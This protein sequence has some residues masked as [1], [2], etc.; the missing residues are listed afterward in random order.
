MEPFL[1]NWNR[2]EKPTP[3]FRLSEQNVLINNTLQEDER[4]MRQSQRLSTDLLMMVL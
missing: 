4:Q 3:G 1:G 2:K